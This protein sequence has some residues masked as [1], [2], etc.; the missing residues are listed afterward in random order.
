MGQSQL[1]DLSVLSMEN[2]VAR[3]TDFDNVINQS[4]CN[5]K[6]GLHKPQLPV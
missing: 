3:G 1:S 6:P 5:L 2:R 4:V